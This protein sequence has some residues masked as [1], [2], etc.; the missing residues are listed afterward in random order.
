MGN[1][2]LSLISWI[3]SALLTATISFLK[4]QPETS[5]GHLPQLLGPGNSQ[6]SSISRKTIQII[7]IYAV[8]LCRYLWRFLDKKFVA[9]LRRYLLLAGSNFLKK[10]LKSTI[11]MIQGILFKS[12]EDHIQQWLLDPRNSWCSLI[13]WSSAS[14]IVNIL[15]VFQIFSFLVGHQRELSPRGSFVIDVCAYFDMQ[16]VSVEKST[17]DAFAK[18]MFLASHH[19]Q[20]TVE[21]LCGYSSW[22]RLDLGMRL[23]FLLFR[24]RYGSRER[25]K[26]DLASIKKLKKLRSIVYYQQQQQLKIESYRSPFNVVMKSQQF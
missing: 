20:E 1:S 22:K 21:G 4:N 16:V 23:F 12:L 13:S 24:F 2:L 11:S 5:H 18:G 26:D 8:V 17:L 7:T 15:D 3:F 25:T 6:S 9:F 14:S 10:N 19:L